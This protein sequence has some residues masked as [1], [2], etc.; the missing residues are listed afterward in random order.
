M[1]NLNHLKLHKLNKM[2]QINNFIL[3]K[4]KINKESAIINNGNNMIIDRIFTFKSADNEIIEIILDDFIQKCIFL[5]DNYKDPIN[6][7]NSTKTYDYFYDEFGT[8]TDLNMKDFHKIYSKIPASE[9]VKIY[10]T[11]INNKRPDEN[12]FENMFGAGEFP[13]I[14]IYKSNTAFGSSKDVIYKISR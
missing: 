2:K 1:F 10:K 8:E 11:Y 4:L 5:I 13:L 7:L 12:F 3:E 6:K 14:T 9:C